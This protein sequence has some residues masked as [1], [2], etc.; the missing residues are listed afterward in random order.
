MQQPV[1]QDAKERRQEQRQDNGELPAQGIDDEAQ[2][3]IAHG[4]GQ[5]KRGGVHVTLAGYRVI[6]QLQLNLQILA[7]PIKYRFSESCFRQK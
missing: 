3:Q 6:A 5:S 2:D 4:V 1:Q 7:N